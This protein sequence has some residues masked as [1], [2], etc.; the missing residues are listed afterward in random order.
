[1]KYSAIV[2]LRTSS[3]RAILARVFGGPE[4]QRGHLQRRDPP[5]TSSVQERELIG[6]EP[7]T[8]I[9]EQ[10]AALGQREVQVAVTEL[11]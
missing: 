4:R 8:E 2:W 6:G 9:L 5:F 10:G 3:A 7:D 1:M 11:A